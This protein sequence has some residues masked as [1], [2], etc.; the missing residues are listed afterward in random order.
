[1]FQ[2]KVV[3]KIK[4][5]LFCSITFSPKSCSLW[6]NVEKYGTARQTRDDNIIRRMRFACWITKATDTHSEYVMFIAFPRQQWLRERA[7]NV[8]LY[9]H[10]LSFLLSGSHYMTSNDYY[11]IGKD[12]EG[13]GHRVMPSRMS[14][15]KPLKIEVSLCFCIAAGNQTE[16]CDACVCRT[17]LILR[18]VTH[19]PVVALRDTTGLRGVTH[20]PVVALRDTPTGLLHT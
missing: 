15:V 10:C 9:V 7:T 1:M 13:S 20:S 18:G 12:W 19:S 5:H 14:W 6:D 8:T 4:T 17:D 3:H 11:W 2:T 16:P